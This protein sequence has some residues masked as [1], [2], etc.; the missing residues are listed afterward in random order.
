MQ[1]R[2]NPLALTIPARRSCAFTVRIALGVRHQASDYRHLSPVCSA[3]FGEY[4]F[5]REQNGFCVLERI[6]Q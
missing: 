3:I 6:S 2:M 4:G 5:R 1:V